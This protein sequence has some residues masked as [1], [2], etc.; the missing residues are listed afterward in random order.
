MQTQPALVATEMISE[1][2]RQLSLPYEPGG[3]GEA[4]IF[5]DGLCLSLTPCEKGIRFEFKL[6]RLPSDAWE[7]ERKLKE[8]AHFA[9]GSL[10][11]M[12]VNQETLAIGEKSLEILLF[13]IVSADLEDV[14][15]CLE[16]LS[17]FVDAAEYWRRAVGCRG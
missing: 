5:I 14:G 10:G 12:D 2:L 7:C 1:V 6:G 11:A 15:K 8:I 17:Q 3:N 13:R 9:G 16:S 4:T